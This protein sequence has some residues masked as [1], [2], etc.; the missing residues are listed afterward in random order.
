MLSIIRTHETRA[1]AV[2]G[3]APRGNEASRSMNSL[4]RS[5]S[6]PDK[7][8]VHTTMNSITTVADVP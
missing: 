7:M 2:T 4:Y 6:K 8:Y 5:H 1:T 3:V